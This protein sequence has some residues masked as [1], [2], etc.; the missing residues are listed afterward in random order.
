MSKIKQLLL[1]SFMILPVFLLSGCWDVEGLENRELYTAI[2]ID[3]AE[4]AALEDRLRVT[5]QIPLI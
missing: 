3:G 4:D 5:V 1:L 2:A